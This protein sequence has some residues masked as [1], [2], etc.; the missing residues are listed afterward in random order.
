MGMTGWRFGSAAAIP[1]GQTGEF[2]AY[3]NRYLFQKTDICPGRKR[4]R[5]DIAMAYPIGIT[6]YDRIL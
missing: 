1:F 5:F 6:A 4:S 3:A 2:K